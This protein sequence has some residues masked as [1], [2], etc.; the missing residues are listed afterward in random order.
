MILIPAYYAIKPTVAFKE[1]LANLD[2]DTDLVD[3]L[4]ETV[5]WS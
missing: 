5:F 3:I 1:K 4:S 2:L